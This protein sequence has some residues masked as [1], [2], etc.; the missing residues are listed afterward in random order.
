MTYELEYLSG[1]GIYEGK[2]HYAT[3]KLFN[4]GDHVDMTKFAGI[5]LKKAQVPKTMKTFLTD[6]YAGVLEHDW[7]EKDYIDYVNELYDKFK[8]FSIDEV[9]FWKGYN[10]ER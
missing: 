2:K 1:I 4:E 3:R 9:S 5:E 6:I 10:T 7:E 8:T